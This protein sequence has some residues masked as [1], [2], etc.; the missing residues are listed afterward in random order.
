MTFQ[1]LIPYYF[2]YLHPG[3][4]VELSRCIYNQ[5]CDNPRTGRTVND[6]VSGACRTGQQ[7]DCEDCRR[8]PIQDVVTTHFT[9]CQKPWSCLTHDRDVLQDRLCR[10]LTAA[11]YQVRSELEQ[12]WGRSGQGV[13]TYATAMFHGYCHNGG[14][15]GYIPIAQP[16]GKPIPA[17]VAAN[18]T[19]N[20]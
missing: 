7:D 20:A 8:R 15:R 14:H 1:G 11:W 16:Y 18:T 13:G 6:V 12:S 5:M 9:L 19:S 2:H 10:Q 3:Q 17:S 4:S